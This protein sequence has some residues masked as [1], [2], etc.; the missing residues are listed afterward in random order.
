MFHSLKVNWPP[1]QIK[2]SSYLL[3]SKE[4]VRTKWWKKK[5]LS[6]WHF[7]W[8]LDSLSLWVFACRRATSWEF[9]P[10]VTVFAQMFR[11]FYFFFLSYNQSRWTGRTRCWFWAGGSHE[12]GTGTVSVLVWLRPFSVKKTTK[13]QQQHKKTM[14]SLRGSLCRK[15]HMSVCV[16]LPSLRWGVGADGMEQHAPSGG[17]RPEEALREEGARRSQDEGAAPPRLSSRS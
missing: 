10:C 17:Q 11:F 13:K 3:C 1:P 9:C 4:S 16:C 7:V 2:S 15:W 5:V 6:S 8:L 14:A 12:T